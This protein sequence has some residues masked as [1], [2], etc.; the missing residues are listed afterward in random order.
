MSSRLLGRPLHGKQSG[1]RRQ[2]KLD[3]EGPHLTWK[4]SLPTASGLGNQTTHFP[5]T[6]CQIFGVSP[7]RFQEEPLHSY[8]GTRG[9]VKSHL[10][11]KELAMV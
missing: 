10:F 5:T 6:L 8:G 9:L 11:A 1:R 3:R 7:P 4:K 2:V